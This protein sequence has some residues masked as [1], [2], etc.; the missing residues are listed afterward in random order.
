[1]RQSSEVASKIIEAKNRETHLRLIELAGG[2]VRSRNQGDVIGLEILSEGRGR[3]IY[4]CDWIDVPRI[5]QSPS[6]AED[7]TYAQ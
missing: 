2:C 7:E 3:G 5:I 1:L 4:I 6:Y